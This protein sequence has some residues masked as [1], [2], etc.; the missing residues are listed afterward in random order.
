M[1]EFLTSVISGII[2]GLGM[3]GGT[4]LILIF[5]V[6][7]NMDQHIAQATNLIFFIPTAIIATYINKKQKLLDVKTG[8][9]IG[10]F[11]AVGAVIGAL[12]SNKLNA[13]SLRKY[14]GFFLMIITIHEIYSYIKLYISKKTRNNNIK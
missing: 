4:I 12:I 14:F 13:Q 10:I 2:S 8:I 1:I 6:F 11:G 7:L 5:T 3:G 9:V